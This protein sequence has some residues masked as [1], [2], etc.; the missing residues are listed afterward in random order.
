MNVKLYSIQKW[1]AKS[2]NQ[3][4]VLSKWET[5]ETFFKKEISKIQKGMTFIDVGSEFGY[6]AIKAAKFVGNS[7]KVLAIEAHPETYRVLK[8]NLRLYG[9]SNV[10]SVCCAVGSRTEMVELH[11]AADPGGTSVVTP[12]PIYD[13]DKKRLVKILNF[14][15]SGEILEILRRRTTRSRFVPM[16][17][18]DR[19]M[20]E[21]EIKHVDLIKID[22][23]GAELAVLE[24]SREILKNH[25]PSL[26]IEVHH[27]YGWKPVELYRL[28]EANEYK[29]TIEKRN[30]KS[31]LS[32]NFLG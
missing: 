32:A 4:I 8:M 27:G 13:L 25:K 14:V 9:L 15:R 29:L 16:D 3:A 31:L 30:G 2:R 24:G 10:I 12:R 7:G 23:E 22:V 1:D 5:D 20:K 18:L 28:L 26:L 17:T 21:K 19:I 11:E 6:Y